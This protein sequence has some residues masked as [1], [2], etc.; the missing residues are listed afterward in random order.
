LRWGGCAAALLEHFMEKSLP[1]TWFQRGSPASTRAQKIGGRVR[2][3]AKR[4][5]LSQ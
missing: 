1:R 4:H 3:L 5:R 2:T